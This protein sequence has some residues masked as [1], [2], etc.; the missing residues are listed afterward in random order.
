MNSSVKFRIILIVAAFLQVSVGSMW[1]HKIHELGYQ[2]DALAALYVKEIESGVVVDDF[3][4]TKA[5]TPASIMKSLTVAS[6]M[7]LLGPD[8]QFETPV[9]FIGEVIDSVFIG[10][11]EVIASGD[12]TID[13]KYFD[14]HPNFCNNIVKSLKNLGAVR[15]EG[16]ILVKDDE[17]T[18]VGPSSK[19]SKNDLLYKYGAPFFGFNY[20]D[21]LV[22]VSLESFN[23]VPTNSGLIIERGSR[24]GGFRL[25][26][27]TDSDVLWISGKVGERDWIITPTASPKKHFISRLKNQME[28][29][30][31][32]YYYLYET[33][34]GDTLA[35]Y[36]HRSP[37][38]QEIFTSLMHRSDNMMADAMQRVIATDHTLKSAVDLETK[39][40]KS[41]GLD[42]ENIEI[43]DGSGLIRADALTP[44]F[45]ADVLTIMASDSSFID[46][47]PRAGVHGTV[48][49]VL[50]G[51][52]LE[53]KLAIKS[54]SMR[55]IRCYAG[56]KLNDSGKPTHV[57][58]LMF[59]NFKHPTD[60]MIR[61]IENYLLDT[62]P[63]PE[64]QLL[65]EDV[66]P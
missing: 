49:R 43:H 54:G 42:F 12:P 39:L 21:N 47:F 52:R 5:L 14:N 7:K 22:K 3:N 60:R 35:T 57:L 53:G 61:I 25:E 30:G 37:S 34:T 19:W 64:E 24:R 63:E 28:E 18:P 56:Y 15:F 6:S 10:N 33:L 41:H 51:S 29:A 45:L 11:I 23:T 2:E 38:S 20:A 32:D 50:D 48:K 13:S 16:K 8:Y 40:W 46:V 9:Y 44:K 27:D 36:I 31:I 59:N 62:F 66:E 55:G 58:V 4:S 26:R 65:D 1:A 17:F